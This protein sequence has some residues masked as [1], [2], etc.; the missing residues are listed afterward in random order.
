MHKTDGTNQFAGGE[1]Y[2]DLREMLRQGYT[3]TEQIKRIV[4]DTERS[5]AQWLRERLDMLADDVLFTDTNLP[6]WKEQSY[7]LQVLGTLSQEAG[8]AIARLLH[9]LE[10]GMDCEECRVPAE[11]KLHEDYR[12]Q[13]S[14]LFD[15]L[16]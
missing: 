1:T 11:E 6:L 9:R 8:E 13:A 12:P 4:S 3:A 5:D 7:E 14:Y 2:E 16:Q 10:E 15:Q